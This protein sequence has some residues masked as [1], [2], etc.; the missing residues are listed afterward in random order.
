M[1]HYPD[2]LSVVEGAAIWMQYLTTFG[3]LIEIGQLKAGDI[4]LITAGSSSTGLA[5]IQVTKATGAV[6]IA[7][8]R[9]ADKKQFLLDAGADQV[10]VTNEEDLV[11]KVM[12]I[13]SGKGANL[14]YDP[15]A[16]PSTTAKALSSRAAP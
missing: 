14:I 13:T 7:T 9:G 11:E 12:A 3:A 6:A 5:A 8:T 4:A 1:A 2:K 15:V 10:I 16:G